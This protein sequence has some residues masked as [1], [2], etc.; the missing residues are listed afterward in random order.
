MN[1]LKAVDKNTVIFLIVLLVIY[2]G[3]NLYYNYQSEIMTQVPEASSEELS[4]CSLSELEGDRVSLTIPSTYVYGATQADL[5]NAC[6]AAGYEAMTLNSDGSATYILTKQQHIDMM[7]D[8]HQ[9]ISDKLA[10]LPGSEHFKEITSIEANDDFT[11]YTVHL[12]SSGAGFDSSMSALN[13]KMFTTMY[14]CFQ[15]VTDESVY[16]NYL[17]KS[18]AAVATFDSKIK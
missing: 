15:G 18:G 3:I 6:K 14:N 17:N 2:F 5:D 7:K 8:L 16:I 10:S 1:K 11:S 13:L 4:V 12:S 9:G